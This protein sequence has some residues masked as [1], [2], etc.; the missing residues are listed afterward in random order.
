LIIS[1][2]GAIINTG[3]TLNTDHLYIITLYIFPTGA[4]FKYTLYRYTT[5]S[6]T[7]TQLYQ[8]SQGSAINSDNFNQFWLGRS[9]IYSKYLSGQY[10][11]VG[12]YYG[13]TTQNNPTVLLR[14]YVASA[15]GNIFSGDKY[16]FY[17]QHNFMGVFTQTFSSPQVNN[18]RILLSSTN[19]MNIL[20]IYANASSAPAN[21]AATITPSSTSITLNWNFP[22][23][24]GGDS[25]SSNYKYNITCRNSTT[26]VLIDSKQIST[27]STQFS[28]LT[29]GTSYIFEIIARN[30]SDI[31][32]SSAIT[33]GTPYTVPNAPI[34]GTAIAGPG[35]RQATVT[36]T[37][38]TYNGGSDII[39]YKILAHTEGLNSFVLGATTSTGIINDL[40]VPNGYFF[41]V[42]AVNAAGDSQPSEETS[43]AI[44]GNII[45]NAPTDVIADVSG[46]SG[47]AN[48]RWTAPVSNNGTDISSYTV[49]SSPAG[50]F[51]TYNFEARTAI[52]DSLTNGTTLTAVAGNGL[53]DLSWNAPSSNG[54]DISSYVI[55]TSKNLSPWTTDSSTTTNATTRF[56]QIT[57]LTNGSLYYFRVFAINLA[58]NGSLS[59]V[60]NA[61]PF[62]VP[63]APTLTAVAG[64]GLVDLSWNDP[65]NGGRG[66]SSYIIQ[67]SIDSTT[68]VTDSLTNS[69]TLFKR[70]TGLTNGT[71]YYFRV[72]AINIAGNSSSSDVANAIPFT[73][74]SAPILTAVAGNGLVDLSWNE[75][76]SNGRD[77]SSYVIQTS[78]DS[79]SW[80]TNSSTNATTRFKQITGLTNDTLYYFRVYA[81]NLA[82]NGS[83]S[84]VAN[85]KPFTV[86]SA[87]ILTAV[88]GNGLV[89]L[90]W[91]EPSN[92]G[93]D[94]SSYVI[95]TSPDSSS[96]TTNSSTNATT[97]F[98][99][100][101][102][103]TNSTPYYFRVYAI[104]LAG[105]G[106]LSNVESAIPFTVPSAPTLIAVA[107]NGLVDLSWNAPSSNGRDISSYV[108][109]TSPDSLSWTT[110]SSTNATTRF[111]QITGLTNG[112]PYYFRVY[113]TN[114]AGNGSLLNLANA[115]PRTI[116]GAPT[117]GTAIASNAQATIN[118]TAPVNNGGSAITSY[119]IEKS[120]DSSSWNIDSSANN[121]AIFKIVTGL[122]NNITYY[123]RVYATNVA[124]TSPA[125][126][127]IQVIPEY[128]NFISSFTTVSDISHCSP[129]FNITESGTIIRVNIYSAVWNST[130]TCYVDKFT[131]LTSTWARIGTGTI[132][133]DNPGTYTTL[134][135][136]QVHLPQTTQVVSG[137][138][139]R[140]SHTS[141]AIG[142]NYNCARNGSFAIARFI[143]ENI[144]ITITTPL[145]LSNCL[146]WLDA[147]DLS[148]NN[149]NVTT[150]SD[151]SG[152]GNNA[153]GFNNHLGTGD[154]PKVLT[155]GL[156]NKTIIDLTGDN[157]Y[158]LVNN[159]LNVYELTIIV[160]CRI[161]NV[162]N[163]EL[164]YGIVSGQDSIFG[165]YALM[166]EGDRADLN[167]FKQFT[168]QGNPSYIST[169]ISYNST[170]NINWYILTVTFNSN[171]NYCIFTHNGN[172]KIPNLLP[173]YGPV[174]NTQGTK[175][176]I[177]FTGHPSNSSIHIAEV[178]IYDKSLLHNERQSVESYLATKWSLRGALSNT[179]SSFLPIPTQPIVVTTSTAH[180][181]AT[182]T[183]MVQSNGGLPINY[184][185]ITN[186]SGIDLSS[187]TTS[188]TITGLTNGIAYIFTI[189]ATNSSY[190]SAPS[191][192]IT[193]TPQNIIPNAP[194]IG[195]ANVSNA[196]ATINWAAPVSNGG[197]AI[198]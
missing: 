16:V 97:R 50:G 76:S 88:A 28:N 43:P 12:L 22:T 136:R 89:D 147:S 125:S 38:S 196:Q 150:W 107:G 40:T 197:S 172:I 185:T 117:I 80:T 138:K 187:A 96:W 179:H 137:D 47:Q 24:N 160:L 164:G 155:N 178:I 156:N 173:G 116:P 114:V 180:T 151:K 62:T 102:G 87:P 152:L 54:R 39:G 144:P 149:A 27:T 99:Q 48:V 132:V 31:S 195:T 2:S 134:K 176:G 194:T 162:P 104:N 127:T 90:S 182:I 49:I 75:P 169:G 81:I 101:T 140:I 129:D 20:G 52:V 37:A 181:Q 95:E 84:N 67:R 45:P 148:S 7:V 15:D 29:F 166:Y 100:I 198:T 36:W 78:L 167:F 163:V 190:T 122:T 111:K 188:I 175:I 17:A 21:F 71:P 13:D 142:R 124:G 93:R 98:K 154:Y 51:P 113:A 11:K 53:V 171:T 153:T 26:L 115:I 34:I 106:S 8:T 94:I 92:N 161:V 121:S 146:I 79:S 128:T 191:A 58:G 44:F 18:N 183:W 65:F 105:N 69:L 19:Y 59:N 103:L 25:N 86:P 55:Q 33:Y 82:G 5:A 158:F 110:N 32:S 57:V 170:N 139:I 74:P 46:F 9:S 174:D 133:T 41:R 109:E 4:S 23:N 108:I 14:D 35:S 77:I 145:S 143:V 168:V 126:A 60:V 177:Y 165:G 3:V 83:L 120:T 119:L 91:N 189:T 1:N 131:A 68:W 64:N 157:N 56:K 72:F 184:Y 192:P 112:T 73:V 193:V 6:Q 186:G 42:V 61:I 123:F 70:V 85:A 118:W 159:N 63:S 10:N 130:I 30:I 141:L 66:I 135:W